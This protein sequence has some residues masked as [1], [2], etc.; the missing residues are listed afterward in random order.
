MSFRTTFRLRTIV[1]ILGF[2]IP[3]SY[4]SGWLTKPHLY[5]GSAKAFAPPILNCYG[6]PSAFISCPIGSIQHFMV[7]KAI[8][9]YLL[10]VMIF[11]AASIGRFTCG[12]ICPFGFLQ[13]LLYRIRTPKLHLPKFL[14]YGRYLFLVMTVFLL[15]Y[16]L[17]N[18]AFCQICPQGTL[19]AGITQ[20]LLNPELR[21]LIG[22]LFWRKI[23]ILVIVITSA[24]FIK[25]IFC[26]S[27]CPIGALLGLFNR[28]SLLRLAVDYEKCTKCGFCKKICPV[29]LNVYENPNS[30]DCVRCGLC[31][32]CPMG[33]VKFTTIFANEPIVENAD[34][35]IHYNQT[36]KK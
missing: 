9:Y 3:N 35:A 4:I 5:T 7:I 23:I 19:S 12:W 21:E 17:S 27:V 24:I 28:V 18:T 30:A 26:R 22:A 13:D 34:I 20:V 29:D 31:T 36:S 15:P 33:A 16:I 1:Q 11:I 2:I 6:C 14:H 8:P 25:R 10:G 32:S